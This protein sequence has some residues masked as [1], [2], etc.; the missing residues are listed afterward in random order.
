[1][2]DTKGTG[3][4]PVPTRGAVRR[5]LGLAALA[6]AVAATGLAPFD[7]WPLGLVGFAGLFLLLDRTSDA[8]QAGWTAWAAATGYFLI[9]LHW[10]VEPFLV[11]VA[12]HGWMAPFA[13]I[14]MA[15]GLA[16]F[17]GAGAA[18]A[19]WAV[20][21]RRWRTVAL[22]AGLTLAEVAR[23]IV[24]TGFPWASAGHILIASPL[25]HLAAWTGPD[26]LTLLVF[27]FAAALSR[28]PTGPLRA[29]LPVALS[30]AGLLIAAPFLASQPPETAA[31]APVIRLMQPN[32]PQ[33]EKWDPRMIPVFLGRM[34]DYAEASPQV[35]LQIWPETSVPS[36]LGEDDRLMQVIAAQ[37]GGAAS[38]LGIE[39]RD[40][41]RYYNSLAVLGPDAVVTEVYDKHHLVPF[42]EYLP[43]GAL[44]TR[45]GLSPMVDRF[46]GF[47]AGPGPQI[48]DL[49]PVGTALP[50]IC[51]EAVFPRDTVIAGARP[52]MLLQITNDAW[53][54]T[55]SGPY[56]HLAQARLRAV[57]QG[58]PLIR[59]AN[60]GISAAIAADGTVLGSIPLG[61]T[62]FLDIPRPEPALSTFFAQTGPWPM[63]FVAL[64]LLFMAFLGAGRRVRR[65]GH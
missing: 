12:R 57:E 37:A 51:Y 50:L 3:D 42:G 9:A 47:S 28:V 49:G 32:A 29:G 4:G 7:L 40:M 39:R 26:G 63:R 11:D 31:D 1:M 36:Y 48:I 53:F 19:A 20:P 52:D 8:R 24:F 18:I 30:G 27:G 38:V 60:T 56:Q 65:R 35:A 54:G 23:G 64:A 14:L 16:L 59:V 10:I 25:I 6:G 5:R 34:L 44:L 22:V 17:W 62:G 43:M 33:H 15:G 13:L 58:L 2:P 21:A 46:G 45:L 55:F 61:E 41:G